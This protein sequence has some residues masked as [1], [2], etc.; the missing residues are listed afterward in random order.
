MAGSGPEAAEIKYFSDESQFRKG[1]SLSDPAEQFKGFTSPAVP[2]CDQPIN[3]LFEDQ[4]V[5][6]LALMQIRK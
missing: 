3:T 6:D 4:I 1:T 5:R 2:F